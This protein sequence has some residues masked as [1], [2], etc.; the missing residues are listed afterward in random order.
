MAQ[1][2]LPFMYIGG[3]EV[4]AI[5][6]FVFNLNDN[7]RDV[8]RRD[9]VGEL[10][11]FQDRHRNHQ[12]DSRLALFALDSTA[13]KES[14]EQSISSKAVVRVDIAQLFSEVA[15][16]N[17]ALP[18]KSPYSTVFRNGGNPVLAEQSCQEGRD[19]A[20]PMAFQNRS[21][22]IVMLRF[23]SIQ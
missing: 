1:I 22:N 18:K 23:G 21:V 14:F 15:E 11:V 16:I 6:S 19:R 17:E 7:G 8:V 3:S 20:E 5:F 13:T 12:I 9:G 10:F 4:E 2:K